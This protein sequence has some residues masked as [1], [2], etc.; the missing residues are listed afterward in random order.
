MIRCA[1]FY[2]NQTGLLDL[3]SEIT[4]LALISF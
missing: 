2:S 3:N 1:I 4:L